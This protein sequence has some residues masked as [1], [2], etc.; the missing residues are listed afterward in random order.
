M[1]FFNISVLLIAE[2]SRKKASKVLYWSLKRSLF[3]REKI[4]VLR[5]KN[6]KFLTQL[7]AVDDWVALIL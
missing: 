3:N 6:N 7:T 4:I 1:V 2:A 5:I